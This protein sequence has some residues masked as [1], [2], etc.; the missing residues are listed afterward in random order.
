MSKWYLRGENMSVLHQLWLG[1]IEPD[2]CPIRMTPEYKERTKEHNVR[3]EHFCDLLTKEQMNALMRLE[4]EHNAI[5]E[6]EVGSI[7]V[8]AF[9]LG[10]KMMLEILSEQ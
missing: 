4:E 2:R 5:I 9:K 8:E 7:F 10:A 6:M 1:G 3:C